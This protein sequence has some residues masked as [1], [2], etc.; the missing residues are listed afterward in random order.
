MIALNN[1]NKYYNKGR[2]T[3]Y[4]VINDI[5]FEFADTGLYSFFGPS[6]CGKT[7]L[8]NVIGCLDTFDSGEIIY[9]EKAFDK[10]IP[11]SA[12]E[13]R[14]KYIGYIF[15]NYN[16][17][18]TMTVYENVEVI[19]AMI[20]IESKEE[21][22]KR[23]TSVLKAV[24]LYNYRKRN[25][26]SL[27]GGER[28]RVAIARAL[29]KNPKVILADEPTGNL[30]SNNTF[31]VMNI[32]KKISKDRLV[33]LV[34]H[35]KNLVDYYSDVIIQ[36][37]D[38]KIVGERINDNT[39]S[40]N[41]KDSRNIYL[42][43]YAKTT[44]S[45]NNVITNVYSNSDLKNIELNI[46]YKNGEIYIKSNSV[47][48]VHYI[49][50]NSEVQLLDISEEEFIKE[51]EK[52]ESEFKIEE[53]V[54]DTETTK[55]KK[56]ISLLDSI[57]S[58][59]KTNGFIK[60]NK[61]MRFAFALSGVIFASLF[62]SLS[63][64]FAIDKRDYKNIPNNVVAVEIEKKDEDN[65]LSIN[66]LID[67][68]KTKD[69]YVSYQ[70]PI[71][72]YK[73]YYYY[74][75]S[76]PTT[77]S[78]MTY[79]LA[80]F[81]Q[82]ENVSYEKPNYIYI[83]KANNKT[84]EITCGENIKNDNDVVLSKWLAET[85]LSSDNAKINGFTCEEELIGLE[86]ELSQ[87]SHTNKYIICGF[88]NIE[89]DMVYV[90][91]NSYYDDEIPSSVI[92]IECTNKEQMIDELSKEYS[93]VFDPLKS[94]FSDYLKAKIEAN[95][96]K[97]IFLSIM[98]ISM[99]IY[100]ILMIRSNMFNKIK[101]IGVLRSIGATKNDIMSIFTGDIIAIATKYF[102][103]A[104]TLMYLMIFYFS[105]EFSLEDMG[106]KLFNASLST[107]FI[108]LLFSYLLFIISTIIPISILMKKT[109]VEIIKKYDI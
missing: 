103:L 46:I 24:G 71:E 44:S 39:N 85:I 16:L 22:I 3:E 36:L 98:T 108:G 106:I 107:Y 57:K 35:E 91:E 2:S 7:T 25:V 15:Q 101:D 9:D 66:T 51:H 45:V 21:R 18:D 73:N 78:S 62:C 37:E 95:I 23:I 38:G 5:S 60:R 52:K 50:D 79:Q 32:I 31:E 20:G 67:Y 34:S 82:T 47:D 76:F 8:L 10:Y 11:K 58:S 99:F 54:E 81:Y 19:L 74:I 14:N 69:G 86:V 100:L 70:S 105:N 80:R 17:I 94:A 93:K 90:S 56:Y 87:G 59:F 53:F 104:Y 65:G 61:F 30:D 40:L 6:G 27:S 89:A 64:I 68:A 72:N 4:H 97:L 1:L 63:S 41:H 43:D 29:A 28:Q 92:Y 49:N 48:K 55:K 96:S 13:I 84:Y 75:Y 77:A 12:D 33:I 102:L 83:Q 109:P 26:L 88:A 42:K